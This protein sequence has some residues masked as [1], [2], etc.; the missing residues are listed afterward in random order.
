[1]I[2]TVILFPTGLIV[3]GISGFVFRK[4]EPKIRKYFK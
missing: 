2:G 3:G 1:M 4:L